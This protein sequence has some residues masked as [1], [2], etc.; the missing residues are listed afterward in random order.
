[1]SFDIQANTVIT[2]TLAETCRRLDRF[3]SIDESRR[4]SMISNRQGE[5]EIPL[6]VPYHGCPELLNGSLGLSRLRK[7]GCSCT[8][9]V[10]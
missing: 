9:S 7:A 8:K 10:M 1:V 2:A 4:K 5:A 3:L 6:T